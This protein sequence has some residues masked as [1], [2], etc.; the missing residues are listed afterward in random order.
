MKLALIMLGDIH[1]E[2]ESDNIVRFRSAFFDIIKNKAL[3]KDHLFIIIPGDI[4][5]SGKLDEYTVALDYFAG[6]KAE[7]E[8]Y[9]KVPLTIIAA[10][11]NHDCDFSQPNETRKRLVNSITSDSSSPIDDDAIDICCSVQDNFFTFLDCVEP[12]DNFDYYH[13]LLQIRRI[14]VDNISIA[15]FIYNLSWLSMRHESYGSLYFPLNVFQDSMFADGSDI[16][17]S[18]FHQPFNWQDPDKHQ[19][20]KK[21]ILDSSNIVISGHEHHSDSALVDSLR[22]GTTLLIENGAFQAYDGNF[23]SIFKYL[24]YDTEQQMLSVK[25]YEFKHN[26][27]RVTDDIKKEFK[28]DNSLKKNHKTTISTEFVKTLDD[29]G[30]SFTHP[31]SS[32]LR[33]TDFLF[34]LICEK[35]N[36]RTWSSKF[37]DLT[38]LFL[39]QR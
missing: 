19:V 35:C 8:Q 34:S 5:S 18:V 28:I 13:K 4:V 2:S 6:I 12:R 26:S 14:Q 9:T 30:A 17:V 31:R 29:A 33:L 38:R 37:T 3:G 22:S 10:P 11:G 36:S 15:F 39:R 1:I 32:F 21:H 20:F 16:N 27:Y 23:V 24:S 25:S 7:L